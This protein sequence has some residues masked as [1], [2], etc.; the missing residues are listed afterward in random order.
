LRMKHA[1]A[2]ERGQSHAERGRAE[3]ARESQHGET[4]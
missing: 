2:Q 3:Y 4:P 1:R